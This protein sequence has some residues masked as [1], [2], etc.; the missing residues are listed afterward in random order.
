MIRV[1]E[2]GSGLYG[3]P[4]SGATEAASA[5]A[6]LAASH[7][8]GLLGGVEHRICWA[9][10][11]AAAML[12]RSPDELV[13][14]DW[15]GLTPVEFRA[16]DDDL[17]QDAIRHGV[18]EWAAKVFVRPDGGRI[19]VELL[20]ASI[21]ADPFEWVAL[22]RR[23]AAGPVSAPLTGDHVAR[24]RL[25]L[26][27]RLAGCRTVEEVLAVVDRLGAA[28][29]GA[30][31]VN[32]AFV[33]PAQGVLRLHHDPGL[34]EGIRQR[35]QEVPLDRSTLLGA[36]VLDGTA[37]ILGIDEVTER[38]PA[39][40]ADAARL[41]YRS[42]GVAT[43]VGDEGEV[44]GGLG[45]AWTGDPPVAAEQFAAVAAQVANAV[46]LCRETDRLRSIAALVQQTL[47]PRRILTVHGVDVAVRHEAVDRTVGGDFYDV[48]PH[49]DGRLWL[50]IGDVVGHGIV[51]SRTMAKIRFFVRALIRL[52]DDPGRVLDMT[53]ELLLREAQDE[54]ATCAVALVD[55]V[56]A[57]IA[58]A[59]AGHLPGILVRADRVEALAPHPVPPLGVVSDRSADVLTVALEQPVALVLHTD[60]LVERR[61]VDL[62]ESMRAVADLAHR[63]WRPGV[64]ADELADALVDEIEASGEDD[65]AMCVAVLADRPAMLDEAGVRRRG[66]R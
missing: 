54:L 61:G 14:I 49:G 21:A 63:R 23:P 42:L 40:G 31:Y 65:I 12:H 24:R 5:L 30:A 38:H 29:I 62:D 27:R 6:R 2:R 46:A 8:V 45:A 35:W 33:D 56:E 4:M 59:S 44:I 20:V 51:A 7:D 53:R 22:L 60:G 17:I 13:G 11:T 41:G 15:I 26:S 66:R 57:T 58:I 28:T 43:L 37:A 39:M 55:P 64:S 47:L 32:V 3:V 9:N 36:T 16:G 34:E 25:R 18:T 52:V 1:R 50:V 10:D 48:V 19:D